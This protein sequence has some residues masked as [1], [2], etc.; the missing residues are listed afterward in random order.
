MRLWE[1][2]CEKITRIQEEDFGKRFVSFGERQQTCHFG[3]IWKNSYFGEEMQVKD[4]T[5]AHYFVVLYL[6][7]R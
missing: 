6:I 5:E 3:K 1:A 4:Y 7:E 2:T